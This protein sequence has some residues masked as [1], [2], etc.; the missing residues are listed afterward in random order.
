MSMQVRRHAVTISMSSRN[1]R[2]T[3]KFY[4]PF[5]LLTLPAFSIDAQVAPP[6]QNS[7]W[8]SEPEIITA[9]DGRT[10]QPRAINDVGQVIGTDD[11]YTHSFL[12]SRKSGYKDLGDVAVWGINN[13]GET[14]GTLVKVRHAYRQFGGAIEDLGTLEPN[15]PDAWSEGR[16]IN[17]RGDVVGYAS[18]DVAGNIE[19]VG[20]LWTRANGMVAL[21]EP[22][23]YSS[24]DAINNRRQIAG[25]KQ[26]ELLNGLGVAAFWENTTLIWTGGLGGR[27][28]NARGLNEF[29][30]ITASGDTGNYYGPLRSSIY[31]S[32]S[33]DLKELSPPG[34]PV[35][36]WLEIGAD[37]YDI[38]D[39]GRI[40]GAVNQ[41]T[42][43]SNWYL[44]AAVWTSPSEYHVL[45]ARPSGAIGINNVG[46]VIGYV[47]AAADG[48]AAGGPVI[49][50]IRT[51][52]DGTLGKAAQATAHGLAICR[53]RR[54][55]N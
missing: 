51:P 53:I 54:L 4:V 5:L 18:R 46:D 1:R 32:A 55:R 44:Q 9:P 29:G 16:A 13:C 26:R 48:S 52:V 31:W 34:G 21:T 36:Y 15:N 45:S 35:D 38:D 41:S 24:A 27:F 30:A 3:R 39:R 7:F 22:G 14:T 47:D 23:F 10:L 50:R 37:A 43:I 28:F 17:E 42:E 25:S 12:W 33:T 20:F 40:A 11:T 2:A 19:V 8:V 49:W 6:D